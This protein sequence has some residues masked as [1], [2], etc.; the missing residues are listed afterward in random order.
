METIEM[1]S[2]YPT[3]TVKGT[4]ILVDDIVSFWDSYPVTEVPEELAIILAELA[5]LGYE[6]RYLSEEG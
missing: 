6:I 4:T 5:E 2:N 3:C 1:L